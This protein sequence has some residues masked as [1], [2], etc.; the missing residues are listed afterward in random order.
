[1]KQIIADFLDG[2]DNIYRTEHFIV[3]QVVCLEYDLVESNRLLSFDTYYR[4]TPKRDMAFN[5]IFQDKRY[6]EGVR[7]PSTHQNRKYVE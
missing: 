4:R 1:M 6:S 3:K 2:A 7:L 5:V